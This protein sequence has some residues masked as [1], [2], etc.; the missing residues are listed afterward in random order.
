MKE[1]EEEKF[2]LTQ[3]LQQDIEGKQQKLVSLETEV[4]RNQDIF[5]KEKQKLLAS[6]EEN[7][8]CKS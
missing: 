4:S 5:S 1:L 7:I 8:N 2:Q 6:H 3:H